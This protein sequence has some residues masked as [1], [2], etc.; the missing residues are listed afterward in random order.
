VT[1][2]G[3][4]NATQ[5]TTTI[6][7]DESGN[8]PVGTISFSLITINGTKLFIGDTDFPS[9]GAS[10]TFRAAQLQDLTFNKI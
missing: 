10:E 8:D 2:D 4:T 3:H 7:D 9:G 5:L 6:T 1:V